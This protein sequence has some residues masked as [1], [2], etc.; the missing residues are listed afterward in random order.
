MSSL[1]QCLYFTT[2]IGALSTFSLSNSVLA[3]STTTPIKHVIVFI[4]EN[5][6]FDS[7]Y[8]TYT[9]KGNQSIANLLSKDIVKN[10]GTPGGNYSLSTQFQIN[11]PYPS[12]YFIDAN[13]AKNGKTAYQ[14]SPGNPSSNP[15]FPP[16]NTAY[17]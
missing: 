15:P 1:R 4:G 5:W 10:N 14:T 7:I 2:A 3:Q 12:T 6:T 11:Q 16:P 13:A 17:V 9:P 8:G